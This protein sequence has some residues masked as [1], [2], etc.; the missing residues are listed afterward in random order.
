MRRKRAN[1]LAEEL[2]G[3]PVE[4][5]YKRRI[6][7]SYV[8]ATKVQWDDDYN[9][10]YLDVMYAPI[11]PTDFRSK[12]S[13]AAKSAACLIINGDEQFMNSTWT[14]KGGI[15]KIRLKRSSGGY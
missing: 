7:T 2:N 4:F 10:G 13:L 14:F 6:W 11:S 5:H 15:L 1:R 3:C 9:F 12:I 8:T